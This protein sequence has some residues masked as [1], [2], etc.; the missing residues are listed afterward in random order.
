MKQVLAIDAH[1]KTCTIALVGY[2]GVIQ[3]P[4]K[5]RST[6]SQ[7]EDLA[8]R[9]PDERFIIE[10][11]GLQE[12]MLDTLHTHGIDARAV[13]PPKK[14]HKGNKN[15]PKDTKRMGRLY[16]AGELNE[17]YVPPPELRRI[18]DV[19]RHRE[20]LKKKRTS[21][22]N[23]L[24]HEKNRWNLTLDPVNGK[25]K[26]PGT[27]TRAARRQ[28]EPQHPLLGDLYDVIWLLDKKIRRLDRRIE[29]EG[30]R[31]DEVTW[32]RTIPGWGAT[33]SLAFYIETGPVTRF[34]T[35]AH[36]VSFYGL[37]PERDQ[38]GENEWDK[39][40]ISKKGR[41]YVRGLVANA[42]WR[43]VQDCPDSD[44]TGWFRS[45]TSRGMPSKKAIMGVARRLV[46]AAYA[47]MRDQRG[48]RLNGAAQHSP[49]RASA[50]S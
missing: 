49:C 26:A 8:Q 18:R 23:R 6:P 28:L 14:K 35:A 43:H 40:K 4:F 17:V 11:C 32:L 39:H 22:K 34:P 45:A 30:Q 38:S 21:F 46:E 48:F 12:W 50:S 2:E 7:L 19:L 25:E 15:D 16:L 10:A 3:G 20:A 27:Y 24:Q 33:T 5:I 9:F 37:E 44:A 41:S 1:K 29:Q 42:S 31:F 47:M 36:V 13:V